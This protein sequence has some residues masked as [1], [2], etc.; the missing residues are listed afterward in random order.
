MDH[1]Q[2]TRL[3]KPPTD[4][5]VVRATRPTD[6]EEL[7]ALACLPGY[8]W[9]TLR[10]PYQTPEETRRFI[11]NRPAGSVSLVVV[12]DGRIVANGGIDCHGGRR[13][14]AASLGM[15]VHDDHQGRGIGSRLL[16]E[17]LGVAD[18]WLNLRRIELTVY[19][20]NLAAIAIYKR[21]G[22]E[23]EGTHRDYAFRDGA[24]VDA[25]AMARVRR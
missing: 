18:N 15:G 13:A 22:F 14:H 5:L 9:G 24:F 20:D 6:C 11:E 25:H 3:R 7:A 19:V 16:S 17:L 8:R 10:L 2:Q 23:I 21:C 12:L 4:T 1:D